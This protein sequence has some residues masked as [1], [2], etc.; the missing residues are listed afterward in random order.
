MSFEHKM[1][2]ISKICGVKQSRVGTPSPFMATFQSCTCYDALVRDIH[3]HFVLFHSGLRL[4]PKDNL[5][6]EDQERRDADT[7]LGDP[8]LQS[9]DFDCKF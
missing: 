5:K 7:G 4:R 8:E 2:L 3:E 6:G 1:Q 9:S